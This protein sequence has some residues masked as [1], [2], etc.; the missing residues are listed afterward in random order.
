[1]ERK[2]ELLKL[3]RE[4]KNPCIVNIDGWM[5]NWEVEAATPK[6]VC[7]VSVQDGTP[8][9]RITVDE[10]SMLLDNPSPWEDLEEDELEAWVTRL[11]RK[12]AIKGANKNKPA[13]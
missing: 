1:M 7:N 4:L 11:K 10:I 13:K 9:S 12:R 6:G 3:L 5:G 2:E 8:K